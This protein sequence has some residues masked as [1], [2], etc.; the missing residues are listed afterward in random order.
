MT[1]DN[2]ATRIGTGPRAIRDAEKGKSST[3]IAAY[4]A[5]LW[6]YGLM[7]PLDDLADPAKDKE[8]LARESANGRARARQSGHL[9]NDF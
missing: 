5:L 6:L 4:A 3:G 1:I 2:V 8:G 7:A 9:D